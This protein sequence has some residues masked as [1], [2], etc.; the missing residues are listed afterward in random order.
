MFCYSDLDDLL[1]D[2][3]PVH[4]ARAE[5]AEQEE[6]MVDSTH[7]VIEE[8]EDDSF[9]TNID[10]D[11]DDSMD[12]NI[13]EDEN[14][15]DPHN[16]EFA[17][18]N[19]LIEEARSTMPADELGRLTADTNDKTSSPRLLPDPAFNPSENHDTDSTQA[20]AVATTRRRQTRTTRNINPKYR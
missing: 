14:V 10:E 13:A 16:N 2:D 9:N 20:T 6:D 8:D 18:I 19:E 4:A 11:E 1:E 12:T 15:S 7:D 5:E 3:I 17:E